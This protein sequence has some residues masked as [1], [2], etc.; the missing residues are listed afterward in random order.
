M[1]YYLEKTTVI[2]GKWFRLQLKWSCYNWASDFQNCKKKKGKYYLHFSKKIYI[3]VSAVVIAMFLK[4]Y[5]VKILM[6]AMLQ[7]NF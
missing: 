1:K 4:I 6:S 5:N 7:F 2:T 3:H